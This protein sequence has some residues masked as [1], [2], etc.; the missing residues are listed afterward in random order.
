MLTTD[1]LYKLVR[2]ELPKDQPVAQDV[3]S[4]F[5]DSDTR[6]VTPKKSA[7]GG[8]I[9]RASSYTPENLPADDSWKNWDE[10]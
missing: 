7:T 6:V 8:S 9:N 2:G 1:D 4:P 5:S 10:G 3:P